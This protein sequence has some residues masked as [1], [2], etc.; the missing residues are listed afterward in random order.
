[1]LLPPERPA[2]IFPP[3]TWGHPPP[4]PALPPH[5]AV[6]SRRLN[7]TAP[8]PCLCLAG[9]SPDL[10]EPQFFHYKIEGLPTVRP[11]QNPWGF[12][13]QMPGTESGG[14]QRVPASVFQTSVP[15]FG[16]SDLRAALTS[17]LWESECLNPSSLSWA[18]EQ[19]LA[20]PFTYKR[21]L[22]DAPLNL[23]FPFWKTGLSLTPATLHDC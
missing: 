1:M 6:H 23:S 22:C 17:V 20:L 11:C 3:A 5:R 19:V 8:K 12:S 18:V 14:V 9:Q 21:T 16:T 15:E 10:S 2:P 13:G 4:S 7:T